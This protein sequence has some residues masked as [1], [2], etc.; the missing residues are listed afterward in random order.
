VRVR[1]DLVSS[2]RA[3]AHHT[4]PNTGWVT[5]RVR[6]EH[7]VPRAVELFRLNYERLRGMGV[8]GALLPIVGKAV[9]LGDRTVDDLPA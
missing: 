1:R 3:E 8:R 4:L 9:L 2:G 7:D 6:T 5:V